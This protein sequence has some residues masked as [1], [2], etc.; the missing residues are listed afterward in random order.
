MKR[1]DT[2]PAE[3]I[4]LLDMGSNAVRFVLARVRPCRGFR[5]LDEGRVQTRLAGGRDGRRLPEPAVRRTLQA[6][7]TFLRP[8]QRRGDA[9]IIMLATAAVRDADNVGTLLDPL[10]ERYGDDVRVLSG[11]EEAR[12][13][14]RAVVAA[15]R[16]GT[17]V[18]AD[19]G[20]GSLQ[21][22]R[23]RDGE[24]VHAASLPIGAVR[25][26]GRF[27]RHDPPTAAEVASLRREIRRR[28]AGVLR[29]D[30]GDGPLVGL[31]GTVRAL[32]RI[33]R[34]AGGRSYTLH[35]SR[36]PRTTVVAIRERLEGMP[37]R[38]RRADVKGLKAE[39]ADIIVA[40]AVV[41]E[42]LMEMGD[43]ERLVF[44][45]HGVRY[46]VLVEE[47]FGHVSLA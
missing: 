6:A 10:R 8:V 44:C 43:Y 36:L 35:G 19:L 30:R 23:L 22:A 9:R 37:L 45:A 38:R 40:G 1:G 21:L 25:T 32:T 2:R 13:G 3:D 14:A 17:G 33:A 5:I 11:E 34:S 7:H 39:R 20:G 31:G 18:V 29:D 47:T 42:E 16:I 28:L 27:L 12:L 26:T 24:V 41:V 4:A 46:G 15:L